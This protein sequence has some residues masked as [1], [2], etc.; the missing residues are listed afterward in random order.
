VTASASRA[1]GVAVEEAELFAE[2]TRLTEAFHERLRAGDDSGSEEFVGR[3]S[4]ILAR[5]ADLDRPADDAVSDPAGIDAVRR[6]RRQGVESI[7]RLL[8]L[9][10]EVTALLQARLAGLRA[11]LIALAQRRQALDGYRAH[12]PVSPAYADHVG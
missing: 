7:E 11:H 3:R 10:R 12:A 9:D 4:E 8:A 6:C 5:L 1:L 2:A